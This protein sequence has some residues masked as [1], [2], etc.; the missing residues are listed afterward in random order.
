MY[1]GACCWT[2]VVM[3]HHQHC[4]HHPLK[5]MENTVLQYT[6]P[7]VL[8]RTGNRDGIDERLTCCCSAASNNA[9]G[10]W[11]ALAGFICKGTG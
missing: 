5:Q 6:A 9:S 3:L 10:T 7:A 8:Q 4:A 2:P 11:C 1:T